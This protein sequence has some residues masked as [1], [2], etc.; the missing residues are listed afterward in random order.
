VP[1]IGIAWQGG[2][3][4]HELPAFAVLQRRGNRDFDAELIRPVR[5]AFA[6]ALHP[7]GVQA[8]DLAAALA[9]ALFAHLAGQRERLGEDLTQ[10]RVIAGLAADVANDAP[11][12]GAQALQRLVGSLNCLAWA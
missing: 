1:V 12:I 9:P 2:D 8:V 10:R 11:E 4:G 5:L 6:D 3:M 7:W